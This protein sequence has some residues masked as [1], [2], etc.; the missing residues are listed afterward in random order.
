[1]NNQEIFSKLKELK[2]TV[3]CQSFLKDILLSSSIEQV[4]E[5]MP[6]L[7]KEFLVE[8][9]RSVKEITEESIDNTK[10]LNVKISRDNKIFDIINSIKK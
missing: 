7:K 8:T 10:R 2:G 4:E 3:E 1:M 6:Y 5:L 9:H